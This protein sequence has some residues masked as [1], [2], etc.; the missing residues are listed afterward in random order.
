MRVVI[1]QTAAGLKA[2][3]GGYRGNYATL[4]ALQKYGHTTMQFCWAY[5]PDI[6]DA[7]AELKVA[8]K[9]NEKTFE[10]GT[11]MIMNE[12]CEKVTVRYWKF[13]N[14]HDILCIA[15]DSVAM[16][17]VFGNDKQQL[18]AKVMIEVCS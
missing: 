9:Y 7:I 6:V 3:S 1:I 2:P 16:I 10:R 4:L 5:P 8:N 11:V 17:P 18:A 12:A 15:L 14:V 13:K